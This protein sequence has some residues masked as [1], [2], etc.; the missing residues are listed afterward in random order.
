MVGGCKGVKRRI[1]GTD[2]IEKKITLQVDSTTQ[3]TT[4]W[5]KLDSK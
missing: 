1:I 3:V 4:D 2:W 5:E